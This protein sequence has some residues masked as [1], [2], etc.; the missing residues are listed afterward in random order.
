MMNGLIM[1]I[2]LPR[3]VLNLTW[4]SLVILVIIIVY[5]LVLRRMK[6]SM[7][8]NTQFLVMHSVEKSPAYGAIQFYFQAEQA[9]H[10]VFR[11]YDKAET[12]EIILLDGAY[13][14]GNTIIDF[15]TTQLP[16]G[17]YF[18]ELRTENQKTSKLMEVKN[19]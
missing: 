1:V 8:D 10:A 14:K 18:Y 11:L 16:N 6:R 9:G 2:D 4:I 13:K 12:M 19:S 7:I 3:L 17:L 5:R 15:D